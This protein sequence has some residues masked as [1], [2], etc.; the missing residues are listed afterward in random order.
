M[1]FKGKK[2]YSK[3]KIH[4]ETIPKYLL[5]SNSKGIE[6]AKSILGVLL[7]IQFMLIS[8]KV[9]LDECIEVKFGLVTEVFIYIVEVLFAIDFVVNFVIVPD[10]M[11]SPTFK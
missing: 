10:T 5:K 11:K 3:D 2:S 9:A 1:V 4:S 6:T 8:L 7:Y